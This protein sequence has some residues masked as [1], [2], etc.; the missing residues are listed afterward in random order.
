MKTQTKLFTDSKQ[1]FV[2]LGSFGRKWV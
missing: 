2:G 1:F